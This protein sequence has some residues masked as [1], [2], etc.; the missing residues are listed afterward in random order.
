MA[1][2]VTNPLFSGLSGTIGKQLVFRQYGDKTIVSLYPDMP[3]R[4]PTKAQ[5]IG[6]NRIKEVNAYAKSVM[7]DAKLRKQFEKDLKPGESLFNKVR[8]D[9]WER[10]RKAKR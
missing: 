3:K 9:F 10:Y 4:K 8:K 1:R 2:L 6:Q 5:L 7:R